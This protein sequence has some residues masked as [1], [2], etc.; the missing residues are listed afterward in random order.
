MNANAECP[1][2]HS[3]AIEPFDVNLDRVQS[4]SGLL[5]CGQC[6]LIGTPTSM[7]ARS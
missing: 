7:R 1:R 4:T 5:A 3:T 2:C 6:Q